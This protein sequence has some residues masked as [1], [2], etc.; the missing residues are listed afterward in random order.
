LDK[1]GSIYD[2]IV[3]IVQTK[4]NCIKNGWQKYAERKEVGRVRQNTKRYK[5]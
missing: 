1:L 4:K 5:T 3:F 2:K